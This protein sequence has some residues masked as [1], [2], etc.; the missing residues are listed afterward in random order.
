MPTNW[1]WQPSTG[2]STAAS[3]SPA[4]GSCRTARAT[5]SRA[6][7]RRC[8]RSSLQPSG[9]NLAPLRGIRPQRPQRCGNLPRMAEGSIPTAWPHDACR[10][11]RE[12]PLPEDARRPRV[13][14][15]LHLSAPAARLRAEGAES[16]RPTKTKELLQ[17]TQTLEMVCFLRMSLLELTDIATYQSS[18]RSQQLVRRA[19]DGGRFHLGVAGQDGALFMNDWITMGRSWRRCASFDAD[20]TLRSCSRGSG[21][22]LTWMVATTATFRAHADPGEGLRAWIDSSPE[23]R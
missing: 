18:R 11:S 19:V 21:R 10:N 13:A 6:T 22:I 17:A 5:P 2:S 9:A 12:G 15:R 3:S 23:A 7:K 8:W 4:I 20:R 1:S 14:V 16:R